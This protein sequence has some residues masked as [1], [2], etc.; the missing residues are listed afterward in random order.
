LHQL[1][2]FAAQQVPHYRSQAWA[3]KARA[4]LAFALADVPITS[5]QAVNA[6]VEAFYAAAVPASEGR[7]IE[8]F[9]SGSTG[10][11]LRVLKTQRHFQINAEEN[12]RLSQGW[13]RSDHTAVLH[14]SYA[15]DGH[16]PGSI[17]QEQGVGGVT[18]WTIYTFASRPITDLLCKVKAP[19]FNSR[20]SV[21]LG[22]LQ[23]DHDFSFLRL[24]STVSEI[25]S[26]ELRAAIARWPRCRHYDSY[27]T[28]ETGLLAAACATCGQYHTATGH[29]VIEVLRD[30]CQPA[31]PGQHGRVIVTPLFNLAMPLLRYDLEDYVEV[32]DPRDGCG[33]T[34]LS[35]ARIIGRERNL[36]KLPEGGRITPNIPPEDLIAAGIRRYKLIQTALDEVE[37]LYIPSDPGAVL[38]QDSAQRLIAEHVSARMRV[39]LDKVTEMPLSKGGK[40][41]M[42]ESR[43]T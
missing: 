14:T 33:A 21:V 39:R 22:A 1:L 20:P 8:K 28:V 4:G 7:V 23:E 31:Q 43:I 42:H 6:K 26:P 5:K 15:G 35:F 38:A 30:D 13:G 41:L 36:F 27:G 18:H 16:A 34:R 2:L 29:A 12:Q 19:H 37:F 40:F 25:V 17:T 3:A 10:V 24:V 32:A 9:T 11:P